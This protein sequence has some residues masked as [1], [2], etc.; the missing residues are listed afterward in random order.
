MG[1]SRANGAFHISL[2]QSPRKNAKYQ[3]GL[4]ARFIN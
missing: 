1:M 3:Q 4:K 2:G